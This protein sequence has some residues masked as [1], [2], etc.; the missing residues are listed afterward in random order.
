MEPI[1]QD[2]VRFM[3]AN[4][5]SLEQ[6]ELL[7]VLS[8]DPS[9]EWDLASLGQLAQANPQA[10]AAHLAALSAR[11]LITVIVRGAETWYRHG[12]GS[13][14]KDK[15]LSRLLQMYKQRPVSMI[16]LVYEQAT[17]RLRAFADAFRVRKED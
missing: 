2:I 13:P 9:K 11:G 12:G 3:Q 15:M 8:E 5:E 16:R 4:I 1:P 14:A 10:A 6:L 7:R 17:D